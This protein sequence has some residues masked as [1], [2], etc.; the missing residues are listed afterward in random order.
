[1]E[2]IVETDEKIDFDLETHEGDECV[3]PDYCIPVLTESW[4]DVDPQ[5]E[6][7]SQT[8]GPRT[9][10]DSALENTNTFNEQRVKTLEARMSDCEQS[11]IR[12]GMLMDQSIGRID[13]A[14]NQ[15]VMNHK[16]DARSLHEMR[17][18]IHALVAEVGKDLID[19]RLL[20]TQQQT[21][22]N[23]PVQ[24]FYSPQP[25]N[26]PFRN[27]QSGW[28]EK[29]ENMPREEAWKR[30]GRQNRRGRGGF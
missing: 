21:V 12:F 22:K 24:Q 18:V 9:P 1:M 6:G 14:V 11:L 17:G 19:E 13:D 28:M 26:L 15:L 5:S 3:C 16:R 2:D 30:Q 23:R 10:P 29:G 8:V 20:S 4:A 27:R 25:T 7:G